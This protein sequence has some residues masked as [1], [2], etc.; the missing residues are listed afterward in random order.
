MPPVVLDI[1][2]KIQRIEESLTGPNEL[3][4]KMESRDFQMR[5]ELQQYRT[6]L[7]PFPVIAKDFKLKEIELRN[8]EILTKHSTV[9]SKIK[10]LKF[11]K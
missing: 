7:C 1:D 5:E 11:V 10:L 3:L 6:K 2:S 8:A 9:N 4:R